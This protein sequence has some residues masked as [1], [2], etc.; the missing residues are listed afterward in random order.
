MIDLRLCFILIFGGI[1]TGFFI[2]HFQYCQTCRAI[3]EDKVLKEA[4]EIESRRTGGT[5]C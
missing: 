1:A 5:K 3:R 2:G 4:R